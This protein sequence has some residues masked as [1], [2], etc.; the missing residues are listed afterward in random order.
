M[1]GKLLCNC[2]SKDIFSVDA[3]TV[4]LFFKDEVI[5]FNGIKKA[6][7]ANKGVLTNKISA[8]LFE[9][10]TEKGIPNHFVERV[11]RSEERRVGKSVDTAGSGA[12]KKKERD[13]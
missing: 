10:L 5:A 3:D 1:P 4:H 2:K 7:I 8:V 11:D 13:R 6:M 12:A 9:I